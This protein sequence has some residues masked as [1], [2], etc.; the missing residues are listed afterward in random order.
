[1]ETETILGFSEEQL[2]GVNRHA[3]RAVM[4][5]EYIKAQKEM[6]NGFP[7]APLKAKNRMD[8]PET[9]GDRAYATAGTSEG[10]INGDYSTP[11]EGTKKAMPIAIVGMSC[12]FPGGANNLQEMWRLCSEGRS[13]RSEVPKNRFNV[14]A[15]YHP[16][17]ERVNSMNVKSGHFLQDDQ[18]GYF[19]ASFFNISPN[20]AK[21]GF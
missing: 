11:P 8:G 5:D 2:K 15:F 3:I 14:D 7:K 21:V 6:V 4:D 12:R 19:D 18:Y 9:I 16:N 1:M 13:A 10:T 17:P 20:E